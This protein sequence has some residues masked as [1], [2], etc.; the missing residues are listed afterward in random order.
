MENDNKGHILRSYDDAMKQVND[1][2]HEMAGIIEAS[3]SAVLNGFKKND[4]DLLNYVS[5]HDFLAN[6]LEVEIDAKC[7]NIFALQ[8]PVASDL[9]SIITIL[10][11]VTDLERVG[12][13]S[14]KIAR[15]SLKLNYHNINLS[16][17]KEIGNLGERVREALHS[18]IEAYTRK[19]ADYAFNVI[20]NDKSVD[21]SYNQCMKVLISHTDK[22]ED[23][24]AIQNF[25]NLT[26][27]TKTI[28]RIGDHAKNIAQHAIYLIH[29]KDL[30]H[31]T[32]EQAKAELEL[33]KN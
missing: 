11:V 3:F 24:N 33:L 27:I 25:Y 32:I 13:E 18:S 2:T 14:E 31:I 1:Q 29:G 23:I 22:L 6:K 4:A 5:T 19:S 16:F 26:M 15:I 12:D 30:R 8:T 17:L 9:R 21:M 10:R 7:T 28:E 20:K